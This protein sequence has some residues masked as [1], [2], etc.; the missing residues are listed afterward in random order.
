MP[1]VVETRRFEAMGPTEFSL[2]SRFTLS[3]A[4]TV[5]WSDP[6]PSLSPF[7]VSTLPAVEQGCHSRVS[8]WL[9]GYMDHGCQIGYMDRLSSNCCFECKMR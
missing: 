9:H 3:Y 6:G 8:D 1:R 4:N 7:P 2:F 5:P